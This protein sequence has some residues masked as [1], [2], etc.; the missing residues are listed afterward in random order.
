MYI[1]HCLIN[2]IHPFLSCGVPR[3]SPGTTIQRHQPLLRYRR[4]HP[5]GFTH[6]SKINLPKFREH[7]LNPV[8]SRVLLFRGCQKH[9]VTR[10]THG[11]RFDKNSQ[12]RNK[13]SSRVITSQTEQLS[14][15]HDRCKRIGIPSPVRTHGIQMCIE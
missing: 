3:F 2:R 9:Q 11:C 8:T 10:Q 7:A 15:L 1:F 5:R 13:T 6:K 12:H 4:T 14:L